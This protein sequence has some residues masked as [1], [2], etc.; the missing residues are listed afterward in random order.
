[1]IIS[2]GVYFHFSKILI[3]W[4]KKWGRRTKMA[5]N[6]QKACPHSICGT[7]CDM[8]V[9]FNMFVIFSIFSAFQAF[10][11]FSKILIF[12][13]KWNKRAKIGQE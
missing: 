12:G 9:I 1:M 4:D 3:F 2:L 8:I 10:F 11:H 6:W 5:Q 7:A 13:Q